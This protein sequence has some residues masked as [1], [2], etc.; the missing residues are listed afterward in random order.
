[1]YVGASYAA[2]DELRAFFPKRADG[3]GLPTASSALICGA[4][5][6][7]GAQ[8]LAYPLD[9]VRRRMQVHGFLHGESA[10]LPERRSTTPE[11]RPGP[12]TGRVVADGQSC[13]RGDPSP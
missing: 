7:A 13:L 3:S 4:T 8:A 2:Y 6:A 1:M 12:A 9:T 11:P 5:A 10:L